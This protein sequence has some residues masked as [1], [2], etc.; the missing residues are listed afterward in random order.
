MLLLLTDP[1]LD[2]CYFWSK[3]D[4][5][6]SIVVKQTGKYS[7]DSVS[8]SSGCGFK[9]SDTVSVVFIEVPKSSV[10]ILSPPLEPSICEGA[11]AKLTVKL[12]EKDIL[13]L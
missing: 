1:I 2:Y 4:S 8:N 6:S 13:F 12:A 10:P 11:K 5:T 7:L 9:V 3:G